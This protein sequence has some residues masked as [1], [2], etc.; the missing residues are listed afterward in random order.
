[1]SLCGDLHWPQT[2]NTPMHGLA[3]LLRK[4]PFA[5]STPPPTCSHRTST[6]V[7]TYGVVTGAAVVMDAG[8]APIGTGTSLNQLQRLAE[9]RSVGPAKR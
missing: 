1:M 9:H 8:E 6:L 3:T 2:Q 7:E 4:R 5:K